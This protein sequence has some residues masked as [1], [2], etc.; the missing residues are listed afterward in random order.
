MKAILG[1]II[2]RVLKLICEFIFD[3]ILKKRK[4]EKTEKEIKNAIEEA[5]KTGDT[6]HLENILND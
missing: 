3:L 4:K 1:L 2:E 6:S 5:N